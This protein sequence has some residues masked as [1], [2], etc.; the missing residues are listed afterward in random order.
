MSAAHR[1]A[2]S[3]EASRKWRHRNNYR[4][5]KLLDL[6]DFRILSYLKMLSR[7]QDYGY[8]ASYRGTE[9]FLWTIQLLFQLP[10]TAIV[11]WRCPAFLEFLDQDSPEMFFN[12]FDFVGCFIIALFRMLNDAYNSC[13]KIDIIF[14]VMA[15]WCRYKKSHWI[16]NQQKSPV[17]ECNDSIPLYIARFQDFQPA[18]EHLFFS[19]RLR[20]YYVM[21]NR[22]SLWI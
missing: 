7:V 20:T 12:F 8:S 4:K 19:I 22:H 21:A 17:W 16:T 6:F 5:K 9:F 10:H 13:K 3:R 18:L 15:D 1:R 2:A 11:S 14:A